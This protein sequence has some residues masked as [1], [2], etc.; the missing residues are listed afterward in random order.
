MGA[1]EPCRLK[2]SES[3][4]IQNPPAP[5][6]TKLRII[7]KPQDAFPCLN[8]KAGNMYEKLSK[9]L[10]ELNLIRN[11]ESHLLAVYCDSFIGWT[12]GKKQL[13]KEGYMVEG[14]RGKITNPLV[15]IVKNHLEIVLRI[16]P[17]FGFNPLSRANIKPI[18]ELAADNPF[19]I[20][21]REHKEF[22]RAKELENKYQEGL[23]AG[24]MEREQAKMEN[25]SKNG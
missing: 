9:E 5:E 14:Q 6:T 1:P 16:S 8:K 25:E 7:R 21:E 22:D 3:E 19:A 2:T 23:K 17:E 11:L 18:P 13:K 24:R 20:L 12:E 10:F 15:A 4:I